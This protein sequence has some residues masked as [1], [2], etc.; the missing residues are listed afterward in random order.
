MKLPAGRGGWWHD[1]VCPVHGV[2]LDHVGLTS[3]VFPVFG[4]PCRHGCVVDTPKVRDA[5]TVL[6]HQACAAELVRLAAVQPDVATTLLEEYAERYTAA[7]AE[8]DGAAGWM[9]RGRLFHQALTEAIWAVRIGTAATVLGVVPDL[10]AELGRAMA[11]ARETLVGQGRFTS[12]YT[13]WLNA[14]GAVCTG[15][16]DWRDGEHGI[17]AHLLAAT[18]DDGWEWEGSTYYHTFVLR[19]YLVALRDVEDGD[20]PRP[21]LDRLRAMVDVLATVTTIGGV[22]PALHDTPYARPDTEAE[23]AELWSLVVERGWD[24]ANPR[25]A[26]TVYRGVGCAVLRG[27]GIHAIVDFGPHG[28][29]HG[30][31]D[32]LA[33]YLYGATAAWQPDPGQV[34]YGHEFWREHYASTAAHPT[35]RVDGA[36]QAECAGTLLRANEVGVEVAVDGAYPGVRA[37]RA[38]SIEDGALIDRLTVECERPRRVEFALRPAVPLTVRADGPVLRTYWAG[39]EGL[40]GEHVCDAA[41]ARLSVAP[42][43]GPADDPQ[44]TRTHVNWVVPDATE[45]TFTATYRATEG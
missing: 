26:V 1:Y 39:A 38:V 31:R 12:N 23:Y 11:D 13:A 9:L 14:A 41:D 5:W 3:G 43:P 36:E 42:G 45:V 10:L 18:D 35:F 17:Y 37:V 40:W 22:V 24:T 6:A 25:H 34:P 20:L 27:S 29:S 16:R 7:P 15:D 33:L 30:H 19:A 28:G 32:K 2:E 8:H 4:A 21:V 44:R